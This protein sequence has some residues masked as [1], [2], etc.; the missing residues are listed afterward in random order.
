MSLDRRV[1]LLDT[2]EAKSL[3]AT[4][5]VTQ[6][7]LTETRCN[8]HKLRNLCREMKNNQKP[9]KTNVN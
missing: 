5:T 1:G 2:N 7:I 3:A 9:I 4:T 6:A 8:L